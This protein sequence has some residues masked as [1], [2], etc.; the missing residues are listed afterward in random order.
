MPRRINREE[1]RED[2][3][4]ATRRVMLREGAHAVSISKVAKEAGLAKPTVFETCSSRDELLDAAYDVALP[5]PPEIERDALEELL[6][7]I[8]ERTL[9][10][11][12]A[13]RALVLAEASR[14]GS[15]RGDFLGTRLEEEAAVLASRLREG[16]ER[17]RIRSQPPQR[18]AK[19]V[20]A[21]I[22]GVVVHGA[23]QRLSKKDLHSAA[24]DLVVM[25]RRL[26]TGS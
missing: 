10:S 25:W 4:R 14:K 3:A 11:P 22:D 7:W 5:Q 19:Q 26:F 1:R 23:A 24:N 17:G 12:G 2:L 21:S 8:H 6:G 15:T 18:L 13:I 20:L 9:A 16:M